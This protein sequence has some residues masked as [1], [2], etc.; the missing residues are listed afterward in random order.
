MW[1][2]LVMPNR[3]IT[4]VHVMPLGDTRMHTAPICWCKPARNTT[5]RVWVHNAISVP[6]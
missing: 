4:E 2:T 5:R 1:T 6:V 3:T